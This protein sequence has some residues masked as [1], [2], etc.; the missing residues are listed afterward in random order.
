MA[1]FVMFW[2]LPPAE[3]M[4]A[5]GVQAKTW[6]NTVLEVPGVREFRAYR[7]P[8]KATPQV[9]VQVEFDSLES[10]EKFVNSESFSKNLDGLKKLGI[11]NF[12]TQMWDASPV[13]PAPLKPAGTRLH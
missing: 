10:V 4:Q 3:Q 7:N 6:T 1:L 13:I 11:H 9:T 5:Y 8:S 2:D 12:S